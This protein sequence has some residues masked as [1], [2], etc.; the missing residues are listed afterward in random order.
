MTTA[1][2]TSGD[3]D[4]DDNEII[5]TP[6]QRVTRSKMR[7]PP[8][9]ANTAIVSTEPALPVRLTRS[10][11]AR[12]PAGNVQT[13]STAAAAKDD[14]TPTPS[15]DG[16]QEPVTPPTVKVKGSV[17]IHT[18]VHSYTNNICIAH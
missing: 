3:D 12:K 16:Y 13:T 1:A 9:P 18:Y 6:P 15:T 4:D 17:W 10:K 11:M 5:D 14:A 7:R 8:P 2:A